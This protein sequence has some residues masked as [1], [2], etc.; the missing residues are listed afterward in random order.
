MKVMI[1]RP[2]NTVAVDGVAHWVNCAALA[3]YIKVIQWDTDRGHIEFVNDG[4]GA[5]NPN[6]PIIDIKPYQFLI[7]AWQ[8]ADKVAQEKAAAN[9]AARD[10]EGAAAAALRGES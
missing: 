4:R 10:D 7:D 8:A 2:D 3:A 5:F 9:K 6:L 1:S